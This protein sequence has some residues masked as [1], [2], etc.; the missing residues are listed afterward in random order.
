MEE[1][2]DDP[3]GIRS[4]LIHHLRNPIVRN[5]GWLLG[6]QGLGLIFQGLYFIL[7]A[8]TLGSAQYGAYIGAFAFTNVLAA[9]CPLGT[10]TLFLRYVTGRRQLSLPY[11]GNILATTVF[12]SIIAVAGLTWAAPHMINPSSAHLVFLSAIANCVFGQ[13]STEIARVFQAFEKMRITALLNLQMN[14]ARMFAAL[15]ML[16]TVHH[17]S[18]YQWVVLSTIVSGLG[19]AAA[20]ILAIRLLGLPK[21]SPRLARE[22]MAEGIGFAFASSTT[23]VYNDIDKA[24]LSHYNLN[25]SNGIYSMAYRVVDIACMPLFAMRDAALPRLFEQ[26]REGGILRSAASGRRLMRRALLFCGAASVILFVT[27][28]LIRLILGPGFAESSTALRWL[29]IIPIFR[30]VHQISGVVLTGA[31]LQR[32]RTGAQLMAAVLNFGLNL[33]LIPRHGWLGA[34]WASV[35]TDAALGFA[36]WTILT[37]I[38]KRAERDLQIA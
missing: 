16:L 13:L 6:G 21:F 12:V 11:F 36:N 33:W 32:F 25:R 8:R 20:V 38:R 18:A 19:A 31:G 37:I 4:R 15:G 24:M 7:I 27:A 1:V 30:A 14:A 5:A 23:T 22:H 3:R 35:A 10:G 26:G 17:G 29:S 34:A 2:S 9:Y 28:P